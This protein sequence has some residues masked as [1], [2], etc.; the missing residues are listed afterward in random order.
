M[1]PQELPKDDVFPTPVGVFRI[2]AGAT[3]PSERLPH[4]RGG[5][6]KSGLVIQAGDGSSPRPWGCFSQ[7]VADCWAYVV[8]PT[9]VGVFPEIGNQAAGYVR[10]P[11]ARGGVSYDEL[12]FLIRRRS[13]PRPWGCFFAEAEELAFTQVFPTPVGVFLSEHWPLRRS[14]R[15]PHARG[16]VSLFFL[17]ALHPG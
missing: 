11:H 16:G 4:A 17:I 10:L 1:R 6:S 2:Q 7:S 3:W 9:P 14:R 5:V 15:L 12:L 8:F 13:S